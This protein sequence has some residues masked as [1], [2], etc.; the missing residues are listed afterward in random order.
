MSIPRLNKNG[1]LPDGIHKA[2]LNEVEVVFG[3]QTDR[4]KLLMTGLNRGAD[5]FKAAGINKIYL[6]GSF[7][8]DKANP[9]DID[10]CWSAIGEIDLDILDPLFWNFKTVDQ[11]DQSRLLAKIKYGLDFF[12][13][14]WSEGRTGKPFPEFFQTSREGDKKGILEIQLI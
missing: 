8:S 4:R 11:C 1:E 2:T 13:A 14:E 3:T 10:G 9:D 6:D 7:T 5:N 12:I